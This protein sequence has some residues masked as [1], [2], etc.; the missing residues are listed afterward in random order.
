M[1]ATLE[2]VLV[3]HLHSSGGEEPGTDG[4]YDTQ[5]HWGGECCTY[6]VFLPKRDDK[7]PQALTIATKKVK[8][9]GNSPMS[10]VEVPA[11]AE[12]SK[13]YI[14]LQQKWGRHLLEKD[15]FLKKK[16]YAGK[17]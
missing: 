1:E 7:Q 16:H 15:G 14:V 12:N 8:Q 6:N 9:K 2:R 13:S 4:T 3:K 10:R 11:I 5:W 17:Y